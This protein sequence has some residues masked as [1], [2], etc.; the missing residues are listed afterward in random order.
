[1]FDLPSDETVRAIENP[2]SLKEKV[3][4]KN[5]EKHLYKMITFSGQ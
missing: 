2:R 5:S 4:M 1:M 3:T